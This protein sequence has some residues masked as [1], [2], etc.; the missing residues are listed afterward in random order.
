M[1][2]SS[3]DWHDAEWVRTLRAAVERDGQRAVAR[4]L[5]CSRALVSQLLSG[6][7]SSP[8]EKWKRRVEAEYDRDRVPCPILGEISAE[9]CRSEREK[10]FRATNPLRVKLS[11]TCPTCPMNPDRDA[12]E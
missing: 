3:Q 10:G 1:D 6:R 2:D 9:R 5:G 11:Q 4:V 12:H 7:Y 8:T